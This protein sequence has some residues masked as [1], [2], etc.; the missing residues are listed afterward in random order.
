MYSFKQLFLIGYA[1]T[2][3]ALFFYYYGKRTVTSPD[4]VLEMG[5][6]DSASTVVTCISTI[7]EKQIPAKNAEVKYRK[8][9]EDVY[10]E[11]G[12]SICE[13][14]CTH[15]IPILPLFHRKQCGTI[16]KSWLDNAL[17]QE[18]SFPVATIPSE[19]KSTFLLKGLIRLSLIY[20][21]DFHNNQTIKQKRMEWT[22][23]MF[24]W[25]LQIIKSGGWLLRFP[26]G[27][28]KGSW[29]KQ[30]MFHEQDINIRRM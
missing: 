8:I 5:N 12:Y 22:P 13:A 17:L 15:E 29:I 25:Y 3:A 1:L 26:Y 10:K 27:T 4:V 30:G 9:F 23:Q 18:V 28:E 24:Q 14:S 16:F 2:G 6:P 11:L 21:N 19:L 7:L 20:R